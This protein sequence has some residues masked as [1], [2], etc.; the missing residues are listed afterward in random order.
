MDS[1]IFTLSNG[2]VIC[3]AGADNEEWGDIEADLVCFDA[4]GRR[5]AEVTVC[6]QR[7]NDGNSPYNGWWDGA[8]LAPPSDSSLS[9]FYDEVGV[10][11]FERPKVARAL[12][13]W[14]FAT[15]LDFLPRGGE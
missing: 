4:A 10:D 8:S 11:W 9:D 6:L 3:V 2:N 13:E 12:R 15:D 1:E 14:L 7:G 5:I